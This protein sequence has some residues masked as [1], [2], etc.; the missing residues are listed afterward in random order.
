MKMA[1]RFSGKSSFNK[2]SL[3]IVVPLK[4]IQVNEWNKKNVINR[5]IYDKK[6]LNFL[7]WVQKT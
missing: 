4:S 2:L 5:K 6:R 3:L 1:N 7:K